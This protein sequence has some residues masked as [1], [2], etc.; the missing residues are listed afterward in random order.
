[1]AGCLPA[2]DAELEPLTKR[3]I[4]QYTADPVGLAL[5]TMADM[6]KSYWISGAV[7]LALIAGA[8]RAPVIIGNLKGS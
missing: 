4:S 5:N 3:V 2:K 6:K 7:A 8:I 1:M